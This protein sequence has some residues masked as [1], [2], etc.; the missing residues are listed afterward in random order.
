[1]YVPRRIESR[2]DWFDPDRIKVYTI[3][4]HSRPVDREDFLPRLREIKAKTPIAWDATP[5]FAI[6][7]DGAGA[8]Y[9]VL[10]W[11][12][13]DNELFTSVSVRTD[14]GWV[15]DRS[16]FSFCLYDMEVMWHERNFYVECLDCPQPD[17]A[18][19]RARRYAN[20]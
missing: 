7:H 1:M 5:A 13:N 4:A 15:E 14:A 2:S 20:A 12:G 19:Y 10:A 16:R 3:S 18:A 6:F 11:W 8:L 17:L 9:L